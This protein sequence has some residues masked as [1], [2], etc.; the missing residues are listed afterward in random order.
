MD[1]QMNTYKTAFDSFLATSA[2][3][4]PLWGYNM[5][6]LLQIAVSSLGIIYLTI[7]IIHLLFKKDT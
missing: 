7:Q 6:D 4:I 3:T 1:Y 5:N 2:A